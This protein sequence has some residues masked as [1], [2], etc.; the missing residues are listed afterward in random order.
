MRY[1][2]DNAISK[3]YEVFR[4]YKH[5]G[6]SIPVD[7]EQIACENDI[8]V[9]KVNLPNE[10]SG[11]LDNST[12]RY[13]ILVN[14]NQVPV[15]QRFS[16]AHELGHYFLHS[17]DNTAK[18]VHIDKVRYYR[19]NKSSLGTDDREIEA[20]IFASEL[21]IPSDELKNILSSGKYDIYDDK[22]ID[23]LA[24]KF[25]VSSAALSVKIEKLA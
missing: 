7:V 6:G 22:C 1:Q 18:Q 8:I 17:S 24:T 23:G 20:N 19:N 14:S 15:R 21:L 12:G 2:K 5:A 13:I 11:V 9:K 4:K 10:I 16:I 3:A 25:N